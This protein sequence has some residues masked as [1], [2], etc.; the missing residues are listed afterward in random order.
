MRGGLILALFVVWALSGCQSGREHCM[1][2]DAAGARW[3]LLPPASAPAFSALS[4]L[5]LSIPGREEVLLAQV[6]NDALSLRAALLTPLG[7]RLVLVSLAQERV[8]REPAGE[9]AL[10]D[11]RLLLMLV[12]LLRW[13]EDALSHEAQA[14]GL[15]FHA[16]GG[17]RELRDATGGL[18][19][20][21]RC[22]RA[23]CELE[24]PALEMRLKLFDLPRAEVAK[25]NAATVAPAHPL[26]RFA[27]RSLDGGGPA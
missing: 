14:R 3:C 4:E 19:A 8:T 11:L 24:V 5:R 16:Q 21:A 17:S 13:P 1:P 9:A 20:R 12:Q 6:E 10:P 18:L 25:P 26:D 7:Q 2:L 27:H 22:E 15:G 23:Q